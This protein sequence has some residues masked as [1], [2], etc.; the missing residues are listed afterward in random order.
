MTRDPMQAI[1][2][3]MPFAG[4]IGLRMVEATKDKVVAEVTVEADKCTAG[5]IAHGGFLMTLADCAGAVAAFLNLPDGAK[6]TTTT[7]SKTNL[8]SAAPTGTVL[9]AT[10]LP[11]SVGRR[12]QVWQTRVETVDGK[13]VSLTTQTQLNL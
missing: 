10:A 6:G 11:I 5:G 1:I 8:I 3:S 2:A 12:L 4:M 13:L 7:E 9:R